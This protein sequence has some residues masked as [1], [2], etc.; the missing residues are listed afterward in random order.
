M[1]GRSKKILVRDTLRPVYLAILAGCAVAFLYDV[2]W[3]KESSDMLSAS[4]TVSSVI[5]GFLI[6]AQ[7]I[8]LSS[9]GRGIE[10]L[11]EMGLSVELADAFAVALYLAMLFTIVAFLGYFLPEARWYEASWVGIALGMVYSFVRTTRL[12]FRIVRAT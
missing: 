9:S 11:R 5:I 8:L 3:P 12:L 2:P 4:L 10:R 7:A 6:S 1:N